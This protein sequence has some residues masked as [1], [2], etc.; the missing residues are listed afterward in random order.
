M[1]RL[2]ETLK[3]KNGKLFNVAYHNYR[4]NTARQKLFNCTDEIDL[5]KAIPLKRPG[6]G[7]V[8]CR[9][10]YDQKVREIHFIP[11]AFPIIRSLQLVVD[12]TVEYAFKYAN[13]QKLKV[14]FDQRRGSDDVLIIKNG[15]VTDSYFCNLVFEKSGTLFTPAACLLKGTKRQRLLDTGRVKETV[16]LPEDIPKFNKVYLVNAMIDP[17]DDVS[18]AIENIS[19]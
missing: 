2:I 4:M 9:V 6:K 16:I 1:C 18:V 17:E 12:D 13:R 8:K 15:Q 10:L 19:F 7:L 14:L 11:Y 5:G 3:V